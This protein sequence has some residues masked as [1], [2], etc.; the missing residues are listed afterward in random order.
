MRNQ[1]KQ[2]PKKGKVDQAK[3]DQRSYKTYKRGLDS[4]NRKQLNRIAKKHVNLFLS[5]FL[6]S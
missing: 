4:L 6:G 2:K 1:R 5:N 3:I